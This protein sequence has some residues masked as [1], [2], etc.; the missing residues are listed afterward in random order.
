MSWEADDG[1]VGMWRRFRKR[2]SAI[3]DG[4][5]ARLRDGDTVPIKGFP[6]P[7]DLLRERPDTDD[8]PPASRR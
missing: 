8:Q 7:A 3:T 2:K 1:E 6:R 5:G 4:K